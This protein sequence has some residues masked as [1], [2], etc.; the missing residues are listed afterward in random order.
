MHISKFSLVNYRNFERTNVIFKPGVN[1]LIG[2]NG[3]G[4][5]NLF[6]GMRLLLDEALISRQH[7][8]KEADFHRGLSDW[9]G[10]WIVICLE[11]GDVSDDEIMQALLL[12]QTAEEGAQQSPD[13]ATYSLVF[14]PKASVRDELSAVPRGNHAAL[15]DVLGRITISDYEKVLFGKMSVDLSDPAVYKRVVGDFEAADFPVT[16][17]GSAPEF[18]QELGIRVGREMSLWREFSLS[19]IPAL[20]NVV[21]DFH[22]PRRNPLRTLLAAKSEE[23]AEGD[24]EDILEMVRDLNTTIEGRDDVQDVTQGILRTFK[25]TVGE[26]YSPTTMQI[27]SE[28]PLNASALFRSLQLY[29][30]E[31]GETSPR[32]LDEMSLGGANLVYLTLKLLEFSYRSRR[33]ALANFLLIEEP[34]AHIHTHVQKTLF[35]RVSFEKTQIIY[36]THS[37]QISEVSEI[38]RVNV[39]SRE[40]S[41]WV[42]LQPSAGL[43]GK[44]TQSAERFLDAVRS[45]LLFARS[46]L[47][48]EGDA[49]EIFLPALMKEAYGVSFDEI[50]LSLVNVRSTGFETLAR[51]FHSDRLRKRCAI[52]TDHDQAF[53]DVSDTSELRITEP[54][55]VTRAVAS[56]KSGESRRKSLASLSDGN[57]YLS[58]SLAKHTFEVDFAAA[59]Q[60]N[61]ALLGSAVSELYSSP[62]KRE[63]V[64]SAL[65]APD[66]ATYGLQALRM[67]ATAKKGWFALLLSRKLADMTNSLGAEMPGYVL[68][69]VAFATHE[70]PRET[71]I[72][73]IGHRLKR[74]GRVPDVSPQKCV[75]AQ[76]V[77]DK[78]RDGDIDTSMALTQIELIVPDASL[79]ALGRAFAL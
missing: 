60:S 51:L 78:L 38:E 22:D 6:R 1:T 39:L 68:E 71:W 49:E 11:F 40:G 37:S 28:L 15:S 41:G 48:V 3:S 55:L 61:R 35:D 59:S 16:D 26:V 14:R 73:V 4:K 63:S 12:Q 56:A 69:A 20:R 52:V 74:W 64:R 9:R 32:Q 45:N 24:F 79:I 17:D 21:A 8:L 25:Q 70:L 50:G 42:A 31:N 46:V 27:Q 33:P 54:R 29:V 19:Y 2:E 30:G 67:A 53:F 77:L 7:D 5:S 13:R 23:I 66:L 57:P 10:H 65:A 76:H 34:E 75:E 72:R 44:E 36:S 58:I 62:T 43:S 18:A 47:M